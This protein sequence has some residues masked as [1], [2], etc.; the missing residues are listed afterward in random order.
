M[1]TEVMQ[2][3]LTKIPLFLLALFEI[4]LQ[5]VEYSFGLSEEL[6]IDKLNEFL[7]H[8]TLLY[9]VHNPPESLLIFT[10]EQ[11]IEVLTFLAQNYS[12]ELL[13]LNFIC[14]LPKVSDLEQARIIEVPE[15]APVEP[16]Q[17]EPAQ[18][19]PA[20]PV[21]KVASESRVKRISKRKK[22]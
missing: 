5:T 21:V 7:F 19:K 11:C 13:W 4:S 10:P 8:Q 20:M 17:T 15:V 1:F 6:T 12:E 18:V 3:F 16:A 22:K 9:A 14:N 2:Q